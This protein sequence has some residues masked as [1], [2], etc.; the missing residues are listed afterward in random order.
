MWLPNWSKYEFLLLLAI[1]TL[2][3]LLCLAFMMYFDQKSRLNI[4]S[5]ILSDG[6]TEIVDTQ[7][8]SGSVIELKCNRGFIRDLQMMKGDENVSALYR[9]QAIGQKRYTINSGSTLYG[10]Y[11]CSTSLL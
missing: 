10:F 5:K 8:V 11:S 9:P 4:C 1:V 6:L 3:V 7:A 2:S